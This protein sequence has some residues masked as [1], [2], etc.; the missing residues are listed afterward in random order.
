LAAGAREAGH[1]LVLGA[2]AWFA[3]PAH[4]LTRKVTAAHDVAALAAVA[5]Q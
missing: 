2:A 4:T 5:E 1:R 3:D